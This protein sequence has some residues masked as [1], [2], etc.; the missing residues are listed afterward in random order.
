MTPPINPGIAVSND[1]I[2][3][4]DVAKDDDI[5]P[6]ISLIPDICCIIAG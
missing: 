4:A 3:M 6:L 1:C 5:A 2:V